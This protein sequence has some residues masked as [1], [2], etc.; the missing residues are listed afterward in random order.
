LN[1]S[2]IALLKKFCA[3]LYQTFASQK[4]VAK[5]QQPLQLFLRQIEKEYDMDCM[6]SQIRVSAQFLI[7]AERAS[8][9][10]ADF[11]TNTLILKYQSAKRDLPAGARVPMG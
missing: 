3:S 2:E 7:N 1:S 11:K 10:F 6:L 9:F 8:I 5:K 4:A